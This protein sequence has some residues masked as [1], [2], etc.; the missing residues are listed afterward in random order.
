MFLT[1]SPSIIRSLRLYIQHQVY[2]IQV[3]WLLASNS[4]DLRYCASCWFYY[5]NYFDYVALNLCTFRENVICKM[6]YRRW[7]SIWQYFPELVYCLL[8]LYILLW[9]LSS[10][11][12]ARM[13]AYFNFTFTLL[14]VHCWHI[15]CNNYFKIVTVV[16]CLW[17]LTQYLNPVNAMSYINLKCIF[18]SI[19]LKCVTYQNLS[20]HLDFVG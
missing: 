14:P 6:F 16:A 15:S 20:C 1:V 7:T 11:N 18:S 3:L 10:A 4:W 13:G 9:H 5:R 2:V 19:H 17:T 8:H 12:S